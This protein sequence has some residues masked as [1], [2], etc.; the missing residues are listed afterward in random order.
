VASTVTNA[1]ASDTFAAAFE[2]S[3]RGAHRAVTIAS[4][5][6]GAGI[7]RITPD[8]LGIAL[9]PLISEVKGALVDRGVGIATLIPG[10]DRIVIVGNAD[11]L[12]ALRAGYAAADVIGWW[13]PL[14]T[15]ALFGLG[16][17][18]ARRRSTAVIGVGTAIAIGSASLATALWLGAIAAGAA[19]VALDIPPTVIDAVTAQLFDDM[20]TT[21][22][23]LSV[24]GVLIALAGWVCGRSRA[25][26]GVRTAVGGFDAA[27]RRRL[28]ARGVRLGAFGTWLAAHRVAVRLAIVAV[29]VVVL[30]AM[31]PLRIGEIVVVVVVA[32]LVGWLLELLQV[33]QDEGVVV[34]VPAE[35]TVA[36]ETVVD[37]TVVE[38]TVEVSR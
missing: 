38:E 17:A 13:L 8:G 4:T 28:A 10:V 1:I 2:T 30:V 12:V 3:L 7:V 35:D 22:V 20:Q 9:G 6:D 15:L 24:L 16:I 31:M 21:A 36:E 25:A 5:S 11:A 23:A 29:V 32:L 27:A 34:H 26:T 19:S 18:V 33:R 37:E 14:G